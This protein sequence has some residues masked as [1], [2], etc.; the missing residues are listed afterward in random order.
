M[1]THF[2]YKTRDGRKI[3]MR[4]RINQDKLSDLLFNKLNFRHLQ[5]LE[6]GHKTSIGDGSITAE[7]TDIQHPPTDQQRMEQSSERAE[8]RR[9]G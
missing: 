2:E 7:I 1:P 8:M 6:I 3:T 9:N 5:S 4:L